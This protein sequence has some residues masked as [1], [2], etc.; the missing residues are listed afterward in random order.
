MKIKKRTA[1]ILS[2]TVGALMFATTALADI[3]NKSGYDQLKDSLKLTAADCS[4]KFNSYT[5]DTSFAI[6]DNGQVL[7]S[8]NDV[9]KFARSKEATEDTSDQ[10][11]VTGGKSS[12]YTY[13]DKT[14]LITRNNSGDGTYYVTE[15]PK[16]RNFNVFQDPFKA[17]EAGDIEK[18]VDAI[19]G[20]LKDNVKVAENS[21]GTKEISGSLT[22]VQIPPIVNA[23]ASFELKR[24]FNGRDQFPHFTQDV[25]VKEVKGS[26]LI[27]KEG[28]LENIL[29]TVVLS[30]QDEQGQAHDV[31]LE[32]LGKVSGVNS[33]TVA[34]PDLNGKKVVKQTGD[35]SEQ[36][37]LSDPQKFVGEFKNDIIIDKDGKF[38]KIGER[39]LNITHID[40]QIISGNYH[41]VY[42]QGYEE[43]AS[44]KRDFTFNAKFGKDPYNAQ[45]IIPGSNTHGNL[46][47]DRTLAT[48]Y[49]TPNINI[50]DPSFDSTFKPVFK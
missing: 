21:D 19:I 9:N 18:I 43:Y 15:F 14:M 35:A 45:F 23:L 47:L 17:K 29:G 8:G 27:N 34:A 46:N 50:P 40:Q 49:F 12:Y 37:I 42:E 38:V 10:E 33:T 6:K 11:S 2:F 41:E 1:I 16:G 4:E 24:E 26:A 30:G 48:V 3:A 25:V 44:Q 28:V 36:Q 32:I 5:L 39:I 7:I 31:T 13:A 22:E 20:S